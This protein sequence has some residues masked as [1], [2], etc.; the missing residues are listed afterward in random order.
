[1]FIRLNLTS[2]HKRR[3]SLIVKLCYKMFLFRWTVR[4]WVAS[5]DFGF[6]FSIGNRHYLYDIPIKVPLNVLGHCI[7][8]QFNWLIIVYFRDSNKTVQRTWLCLL[9][10]ND[11]ALG[12]WLSFYEVAQVSYPIFTIYNVSQQRIVETQRWCCP[13]VACSHG[14]H[15]CICA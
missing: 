9:T 3:N 7:S 6:Y 5:S 1:M 14:C 15:N 4:T 12:I 10:G 2:N 11:Q 13:V 8:F